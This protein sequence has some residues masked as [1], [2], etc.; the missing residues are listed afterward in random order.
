MNKRFAYNLVAAIA[1]LALI[2]YFVN[3]FVFSSSTA[4]TNVSDQPHREPGVIY[5]SEP[6][7]YS[8]QTLLDNVNVELIETP[9]GQ[10]LL[11]ITNGNT[12]AVDVTVEME[13]VDEQGIVVDDTSEYLDALDANKMVYIKPYL[14]EYALEEINLYVDCEAATS[15]SLSQ[16]IRV[17][18]GE[19]DEYGDIPVTASNHSNYEPSSVM[20]NLLFYDVDNNLLGVA[21]GYYF[22]LY[23]GASETDEVMVPYDQ[24]YD[25]INYDHIETQVVSA[26]CYDVEYITNE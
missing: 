24:N 8:K 15:V 19:P 23:P 10:P 13:V 26:P 7:E 12:I 14:D 6:P 3:Q 25:E 5:I 9:Y 16:Y 11:A 17:E 18:M 1:I 20:V 2:G 21:T 4:T 22:D